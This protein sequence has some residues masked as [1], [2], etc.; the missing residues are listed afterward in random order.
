MPGELLPASLIARDEQTGH[1]Y[2]KLPMP[3]PE[4]VQKIIELFGALG[5][6]T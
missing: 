1:S 2:L 5:K 3:E 6:R 4:T